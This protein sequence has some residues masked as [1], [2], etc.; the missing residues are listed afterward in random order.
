MT[1]HFLL[2]SDINNRPVTR[3]T[4]NDFSPPRVCNNSTNTFYFTGIR[5]WNALP[6][7]VKEIKNYITFKEKLKQTLMDEAKKADE[8]Q[9]QYN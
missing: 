8:D 7:K 4:A 2:L 9:F 5:D 1:E 6:P 3:A